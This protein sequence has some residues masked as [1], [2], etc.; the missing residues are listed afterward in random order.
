MIQNK[1]HILWIILQNLFLFAIFN[2]LYSVILKKKFIWSG[3]NFIMACSAWV[4]RARTLWSRLD[5]L[6]RTLINFVQIGWL[7][8]SVLTPS[9]QIY[10]TSHGEIASFPTWLSASSRET[11]FCEDSHSEIICYMTSDCD[12][13]S[14]VI[15]V[16]CIVL[17]DFVKL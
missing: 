8:R 2:L 1:I 10:E 7:L 11:W 15:I 3:L 14:L 17:R 5:G 4:Q 12:G 13:I 9:F 16:K 6:A